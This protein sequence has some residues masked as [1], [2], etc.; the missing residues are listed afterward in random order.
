MPAPFV[1]TT[2]GYPVLTSAGGEPIRFRT[3]KHF[4]VLIRLA[5]AGG[6]PCSRDELM[7]M[8]WP[9]VTPKQARHSLAQAIT[10]I[11]SKLARQHVLAIRNAVALAPNAV[12]VDVLELNDAAEIRGPFLE[13]FEIPGARGFDQWKDE[14]TSRLLPRIRDALVR[15]MAGGRRR[16]DFALVEKHAALLLQFDPLSEDGVRGIMEARAWAGDRSSA[17]KFFDAYV[18]QLTEVLKAK[19]SA[20]VAR[21]ATLLREGRAPSVRPR[22]VSEPSARRERRMEAETLIGRAAEFSVLYDCWQQAR[23][24]TP[25]FA[26]V[27]GDPGVGKTT[28]ANA[29]LSTCQLE[30]AVVARVQA[31]EAERELPFAVLAE[32]IRQLTSQRTIVG[33]DPVALAELGRICPE[34]IAAFPGVPAPG[35]WASEVV[36]LRLADALLKTVAAASEE[37]PVVL[38]VDD[39]HAADNSSGAILHMLARKV[40]KLRLLVMLVGRPTELRLA[41]ASGALV[42]DGGIEGLSTIEL[43]GLASAD[44]KTLVTRLVDQAGHGEPPVDRILQAGGGNPLALELLAREWVDHGPESLLRDLE[45]IN[46]CPVPRI[47]IP[48]V[49][50]KVFEREV[51][52]LD[53]TLRAILDVAA[54]LGRRLHEV[55][56]YRVG[57]LSPMAASH[58]L[59]RL[60]DE[61]F[62][63][64]VQGVLEFR[65]ELIR[66]QAYYAITLTGREHLHRAVG[67]ALGEL[68]A[69][70]LAGSE[71]E[72]AWHFL[73]GRATHRALEFAL[74]GAAH[75]LERGA[76]SEAERVLAAIVQDPALPNSDVRVLL[77]LT[78]AYL[79]QSKAEEATPY[80]ETL[81]NAACTSDIDR[82]KIAAMKA[83]AEYML[84]RETGSRH[85]AAAEEALAAAERSRDPV[86]V[87]RSLF[88]LARA[89][90]ETGNAVGIGRVRETINHLSQYAE[91][92]GLPMLHYTEAYCEFINGSAWRACTCVSRALGLAQA[93][94][95]PTETIP[96]LNGL[97]VTKYYIGECDAARTLYERALSLAR[98]LG[99][100]SWACTLATNICG[101]LVQQGKHAEAIDIGL[102]GVR[103]A[104]RAL[105]QPRGVM[106][107]T[108]LADAYVLAGHQDQALEYLDH[109]QRMV[110]RESNWEPRM[111]FHSEGACIWL[112]L[113]D[114]ERALRAITELEHVVGTLPFGPNWGIYERLR[115]FKIAHLEGPDCALL[116]ARGARE[117]F[118]GRNLLY[119]IDANAAVSWLERKVLGSIQPETEAGLMLLDELG[120]RGK[121]ILLQA[122]GFLE[123]HSVR[124]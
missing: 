74:Q 46:T 72:I 4:A 34:V 64:D 56:L 37:R 12:E 117:R 47:G 70:E 79:D 58:G 115:A 93:A 104:R 114:Q 42:A 62:L 10:V 25:R 55:D 95:R 118:H 44:A 61:G 8:L 35:E 19:P 68:P 23:R 33:A 84:A 7:E 87:A 54:V 106:A 63:R 24:G 5:L 65:N 73:R 1:L 82:A 59:A 83:S 22:V 123:E 98:Q 103:L 96:L 26:V 57:G 91:Y 30:G 90:G 97:A 113:G 50:R 15:R 76:A 18:A 120:L 105:R 116:T 89:H 60:R 107:F 75:S 13:G 31:Y 108:N 52:R 14:W 48:P 9:D 88:G 66:A 28:L 110:E 124:P 119:E 2:L 77:L 69:R 11:K 111:V 86:L 92:A 39:V 67:A 49:V 51:R 43:D 6:R 17:L 112:A 81:H 29:F 102:E 16:G 41:G 122:Q 53:P 27:T 85:S 38:V 40:A 32:L 20:D 71:L 109:A 78:Q 80:L 94:G 36:P 21:M 99:D 3:R 121:K 45:A 101:V 100:D